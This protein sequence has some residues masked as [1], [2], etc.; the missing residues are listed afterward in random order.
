MIFFSGR[1]CRVKISPQN[2]LKHQNI[3]NINKQVS[4][5]TKLKIVE[6]VWWCQS[7]AFWHLTFYLFVD[8]HQNKMILIKI[9]KNFCGLKTLRALN[10]AAPELTQAFKLSSELHF[11]LNNLDWFTVPNWCFFGCSLCSHII[12]SIQLLSSPKRR[13][14]GNVSFCFPSLRN[15]IGFFIWEKIP[16]KNFSESLHFCWSHIWEASA[17]WSVADLISSASRCPAY[18]GFPMYLRGN[19]GTSLPL[20]YLTFYLQLLLTH[21]HWEKPCRGGHTVIPVKK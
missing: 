12:L 9:T 18:S 14:G 16:L 7:V 8:K 5:R 21:L 13:A 20:R 1:T 11:L 6:I 10:Q 19:L 15:Y 2:R 3:K 17:L 4:Q